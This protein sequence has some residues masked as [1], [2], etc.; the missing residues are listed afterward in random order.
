MAV[1]ESDVDRVRTL[2]QQG[3]DP[4]HPIYLTEAWW[5]K[6]HGKWLWKLPPLHTA[7]N[8]GS[9]GIVK[10][11]VQHRADITRGDG[12][13]SQTPLHCA[14]AGGNK[15]VV[16]YLIREAGCKVGESVTKTHYI[17]VIQINIIV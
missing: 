12:R 4:N 1:D 7:C 10:L 13:D 11:L 16:D 17:A 9:L 14:C 3:A 6:K 2:L 5:N 15:E 8:T